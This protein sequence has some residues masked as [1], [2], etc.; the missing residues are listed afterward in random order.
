M[1]SE[2]S[3]A[4]ETKPLPLL[5]RVTREMPLEWF[6][7]ELVDNGYTEELEPDECRDWFKKRGANMD[8]VER[9]LDYAWNFGSYKPVIV[10]I[11]NPIE[12]SLHSDAVMPNV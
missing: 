12:V 6:K 1:L 7:L 9:A 3:A 4:E 11:A 2:D 8:S 10:S 5:V